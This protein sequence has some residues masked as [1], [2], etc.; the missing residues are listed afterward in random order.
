MKSMIF[1]HTK[2]YF[3]WFAEYTNTNLYMHK[4]HYLYKYTD[5]HFQSDV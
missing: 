5:S 2:M 4:S 1:L 3:A